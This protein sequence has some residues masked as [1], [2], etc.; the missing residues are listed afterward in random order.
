MFEKEADMPGDTV[1]WVSGELYALPVCLPR[2]QPFSSDFT[3]RCLSTPG[4]ETNA[5]AL[6]VDPTPL[7]REWAKASLGSLSWKDTL[8]SAEGV[9][10]FFLF[11]FVLCASGP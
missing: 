6:H 7:L 8:V 1:G 5:T 10:I 9:S 2:S 4:S 11:S 3:R